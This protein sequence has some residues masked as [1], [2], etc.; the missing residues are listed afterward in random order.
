[1]TQGTAIQEAFVSGELAPAIYGR[2]T[3]PKYKYGASTMRNGFINFQGG[4]ASRAGSA[5]VGM[6]KQGAP[7]IGGVNDSNAPPRP[8]PFQV[9]ITEAY[10]LEFGDYYMRPIYRGAYITEAAVTV[11]TVSSAGLFT[12]N[13]SHGYSVGDWVFDQGN[14]G[15]N[16]LTW[17]IKSIPSA[18]TF[19]VEDLFGNGIFN[20]TSSTGGTVS[21][22]YTVV[23]PYAAIDLPYLKYTQSADEMSLTCYNQTTLTEYPPYDLQK[24]GAA[25]WVFTETTYESSI[26]PP[27]GVAATAKNSTTLDTWYS[28]VVTSVDAT[29]NDESIASTM[30]QVHN[31]DISINAGSNTITWEQVTNALNYNIYSAAPYYST[32]ATAIPQ[33]GVPYG[34]LGSAIGA[35]FID[36]NTSPDFT[37]TPPLHNDPFSPG[38]ITNVSVTDAGTGLS[39][40]TVGF[41][42]TTSTGSG[43]SGLPLVSTG[44]SLYGFIITDSGKNYAQ[45]DT[46]AITGGGALAATGN[47]TFSANPADTE[48]IVL[49]G[50]TWTFVT[51]GATGNESNLGSTLQQTLAILAGALAASGSSSLNIANYNSDDTHLYI[52]YG[53]TGTSGNS[54]TLGAG[55]APATASG[56]T[57]SGGVNASGSGGATVALTIGTKSGAYPG[58]VSY[59]QERRAYGNT[60]NNPDTYYMSQPGAY[61]N[62][63]ASIPSVASD[64]IVGTPWGQ[65]VNG[66]QFMTPMPGGLVLF[67]GSGA[68]QLNGG[69]SIAISPADQNAQPQSRYGCS[70][71]VPPI[72]INFHILFVRENDG[73]V[74]DLVYNFWANIYTAS[75]I[76][77]FSTHLFQGYTIKQWAY[78]EKPYKLVWGVRNDGVL[79]SLTYIAEQEE[80]GWARHDTNGL[81]VGICNIEEP[82]VDAIYVI[83]QRYVNGMWVYYHERFDNRLW[84][85]SEDC[86]CVDAGLTY[87]ITYPNATLYASA[88]NGTN[89]IT[90]T[91]V[92]Y[93]GT[94]YTN[95]VAQAID[96]TGVGMGAFLSVTQTDGV[97]NAPVPTAGGENY[98]AGSTSIVITDPTGSGAVV[99]PV[100]TNYVTFTASSS[101]FNS[102]N[103]GD[104]IRMGNGRATIVT[105]LTAT[106][107]IANITSPITAV[108]NS[109]P[110]NMPIPAI[111]GTWSLALPTSTISGLNHL[112]GLMVTGLA[113]GGVIPL[114]AV[115][116]GSIT[117]QQPASAIN[118]GLPF[119]P[120]L[121]LLELEVPSA[122]GTIQTKRK[123]IPSVGIKY[124]DSRGIQVGVNQKD[125][126]TLPGQPNQVWENM[127]EIKQRNQSISLGS[128]IPLETGDYFINV[129]SEWDV[130]GQVAVQMPYPL[131]CNVDAIVSYH[132]TG[133]LPG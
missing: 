78:S 61:N 102:D 39:Q 22:I 54:Y 32:S 35:S 67:T 15:F 53:T 103:V 76:T 40:S 29:T 49:D 109:D 63:D 105:F 50:V 7:N 8:I 70:A 96:S 116:N 21:R 43:F 83:V 123:N 112:E 13:G 111:A 64:A 99:Y 121:Q 57:L 3:H 98:T 125:A 34:Y 106:Q 9:S 79:L 115:A 14:T 71:I 19:V 18:T 47:F 75:D 55:T 41:T 66:I 100:I 25:D 62:M 89:N 33:L 72:P 74:Y 36:N 95:P 59:F 128:P 97:L 30:V 84:T 48:T 110:N 119:L 24:I 122:T 114:Q 16:G 56:S 27:L 132:N 133:D 12:T 20:P 127:V 52:T 120:Q 126:A 124:H 26:N 91:N 82:L 65:Q 93:G 23:S 104:I 11:S 10:D 131:P 42:I 88:A 130:M 85:N 94:S 1:M 73:I 118:I 60:Q 68:W 129:P 28:Y 46:M 87:P 45:T 31:N 69:N 108:I 44:G 101:V 17:V 4:F 5:Y 51:S 81:Y 2:V 77:V 92:A 38:Q 80:N 86:F 58:V 37:T 6:C 117:L 90:S 107:V 113:D